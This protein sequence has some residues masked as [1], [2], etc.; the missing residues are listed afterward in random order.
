MEI[1]AKELK[2]PRKIQDEIAYKSHQNAAKATAEGKFTENIIAIDGISEDQLIRKDTTLEKLANL[3]PVF[4]RTEAGTL[5]AGNSSPLTDGAAAV[6]IMSSKEAKKQ[7]KEVLAYILD[8]EYSAIDPKEG[9][10]MAPAVAIPR[11]LARNNLNFSDFDLIEIHEAFGAQVAANI[12]AWEEGLKEEAVGS[13]DYSKVNVLGGSIAIGHPFAATGGRIVMSLAG[14]MKRRDAKL[15]LISIC[16]A[17]GMAGAM[18][19][20]RD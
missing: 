4:D 8:Y 16:A 19:L 2:I 15:G 12:K 14:E 7:N 1:T 17:G 10:L 11:L 6:V 9:L 20:K 3:K 13:L 5:T 18:I